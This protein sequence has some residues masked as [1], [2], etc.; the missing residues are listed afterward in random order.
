ML[1]VFNYYFNCC[2]WFAMQRGRTGNTVTQC[3]L[4]SFCL[5]LPLYQTNVRAPVSLLWLTAAVLQS[6]A[7]SSP[8]CSV[9]ATQDAAGLWDRSL[10]CARSGVL[11]ST[12][13]NKTLTTQD[14]CKVSA[15][16]NDQYL[17]CC[18]VMNMSIK[19]GQYIHHLPS[20]VDKKTGSPHSGLSM[21]WHKHRQ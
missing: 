5:C 11:V 12:H 17:C 2:H 3:P 21:I 14:T 9:A 16:E 4:I 6:W 8:R 19:L 20:S 7:V 1:T 18:K 13:E 10:R 15:A